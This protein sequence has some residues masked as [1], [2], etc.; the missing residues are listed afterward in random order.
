MFQTLS[1]PARTVVRHANVPRH[2]RAHRASN[3]LSTALS[4]T[5]TASSVE[6]GIVDRLTSA[7]LRTRSPQVHDGWQWDNPY[8]LPIR[9]THRALSVTGVILKQ[10]RGVCFGRPLPNE[11]QLGILL[12]VRHPVRR[13]G[14]FSEADMLLVCKRWYAL[15]R[16]HFWKKRWL[17][18]RS[19]RTDWVSLGERMGFLARNA[20]I[21]H[22]VKLDGV[23]TDILPTTLEQ[24]VHECPDLAL[25]AT[26]SV[27]KIKVGRLD[28]LNELLLKQILHHHQEKIR[29]FEF[30]FGDTV[31]FLGRRSLFARAI[32]VLPAL[33]RVTVDISNVEEVQDIH[34]MYGNGAGLASYLVAELVGRHDRVAVRQVELRL[35]CN[36]EHE[37]GSRPHLTQSHIL[38]AAQIYDFT[39]ELLRDVARLNFV[40]SFQGPLTAQIT[41]NL[42]V[43]H[44]WAKAND[45]SLI[46]M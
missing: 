43:L 11:L 34:S 17:N 12:T 3:S 35:V 13:S 38:L 10:V 45:I 24:A 26:C 28:N 37:E 46:N 4:D 9:L 25:M 42:A 36:P 20:D 23:L 30:Q 41:H 5:S 15:H 6:N 32:L 29:H 39:R 40:V 2:R 33:R 1:F 18:L 19:N 7:L 21:V 27:E 14:R 16:R 22:N 44:T 31:M 8:R